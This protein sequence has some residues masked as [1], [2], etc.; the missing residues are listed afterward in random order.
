[1]AAEKAVE[2]GANLVA[3]ALFQVMTLGASCLEEVGSLLRVTYGGS[4]YEHVRSS[5]AHCFRE[6][7]GG[8]EPSRVAMTCNLHSHLLLLQDH[9]VSSISLSKA[10]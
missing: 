6:D 2:V 8:R 7:R 5:S 3:L 10:M 9:V 1:M 4:V